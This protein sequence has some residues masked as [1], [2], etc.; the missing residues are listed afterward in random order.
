MTWMLY[1]FCLTG[2][3]TR[4][5][6]KALHNDTWLCDASQL[7]WFTLMVEEERKWETT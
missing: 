4:R 6:K 7:E 2:S 3:E 5:L 1:M